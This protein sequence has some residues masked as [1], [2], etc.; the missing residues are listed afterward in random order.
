MAKQNCWE[1]M[2]CGRELNGAK[3]SEK[4]VCPAA[5]FTPAD[6]FAGGKN[7][8]RACVY[9]TGTFC[10]GTILGTRKDMTKN[11]IACEFYRLLKLEHGS[12][13]FVL[14]FEDYV[15]KNKLRVNDAERILGRGSTSSGL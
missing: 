9:V 11:C 12:E 15:K 14:S 5:S 13:M 3:V 10:S 1:F 4:G 6:G 8:G 7:G 2:H